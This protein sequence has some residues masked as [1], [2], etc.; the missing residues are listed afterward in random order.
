[1]YKRHKNIKRIYHYQYVFLLN[2]SFGRIKETS[3]KSTQNDVS[4]T[5]PKYMLLLT[6][7]KID[8]EEVIF[9]ESCFPNLFRISEY[10]E[11]KMQFEFSRFY[12]IYKMLLPHAKL[13]LSLVIIYRLQ[14]HLVI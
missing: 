7:I 5:L 4:F 10:F 1:M 9:S 11:K 3:Q 6:V 8:H 12:C 13:L 14:C 2:I